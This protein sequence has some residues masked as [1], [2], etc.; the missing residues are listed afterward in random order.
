MGAHSSGAFTPEG[1]LVADDRARRRITIGST[2]AALKAPVSATFKLNVEKY[3]Y[4]GQ[5]FASA[6]TMICAEAVVMF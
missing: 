2:V 5:S 6:P 3:L 1:D 4:N